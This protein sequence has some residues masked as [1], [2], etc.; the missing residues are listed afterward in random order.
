M[1]RGT[2]LGTD[3]IEAEIWD[4]R[5]PVVPWKALLAEGIRLKRQKQEIMRN[6]RLPVQGQVHLQLVGNGSTCPDRIVDRQ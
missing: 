6:P 5:N 4:E 3:R 2:R 1:K